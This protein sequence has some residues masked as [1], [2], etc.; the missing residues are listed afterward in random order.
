MNAHYHVWI[1]R[2]FWSNY[3]KSLLLKIK[4]EVVLTHHWSSYYH[5]SIR[6][7]WINSKTVDLRLFSEK[8]L[9]RIPSN[10]SILC[11]NE[12]KDRIRS[13]M[14]FQRNLLSVFS[15]IE[16]PTVFFNSCTIARVFFWLTILHDEII[17][18]I[19]LLWTHISKCCSWVDKTCGRRVWK[20]QSTYFNF[21]KRNF[22]MRHWLIN[23]EPFYSFIRIC[24]KRFIMSS[25]G[26]LT[27]ILSQA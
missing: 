19:F 21:L 1:W 16:L 14:I 20:F 13:K 4:Y 26:K 5:F 15:S 23:R 27:S 6:S 9:R 22:I 2:A 17:K 10:S 8:V 11:V 25:Y 3:T 7:E 12:V 24:M 18:S